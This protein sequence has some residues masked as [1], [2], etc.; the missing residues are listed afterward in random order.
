[1]PSPRCRLRTSVAVAVGAMLAIAMLPVAADAALKVTKAELKKGS[2]SV[3]GSGAGSSSTITWEGDPVAVASKSGA[4]KFTTTV[5]PA[6]LPTECLA[7][8]TLGDGVA[9]VE[10]LISLCSTGPTGVAGPPGPKG[11]K[12]DPGSPGPAGTKGDPGPDGP[13]GPT[14]DPGPAGPEGP[15]G[16]Q[17]PPGPA[18]TSG[19]G[20]RIESIAS[21]ATS[22][23]PTD[24]TEA[25][26]NAGQSVTLHGEGL[27]TSSDV[28]L[29]YVDV[30][31]KL[32]V[33]HLEPNAAAPDGKTATVTVP[34]YAN[35]AFPVQLAGSNS[36]VP[37][38]IVPTLDSVAVQN[39]PTLLGSG[40]VEGASSYSFSRATFFD[41]P[42]DRNDI[43]VG[44]DPGSA[45]PNGAAYVDRTALPL[46]GLG[47]V[48]V[49]VTTTG[50]TSVA[51]SLDDQRQETIGVGSTTND[52]AIVPG[53]TAFWVIDNANPG[54]ILK[55]DATIGTLQTITMSAGTYGTAFTFN[56]AGLQILGASMTLNATTVAAGSLLVLN[57]SPNT[58]RIVAI[59]PATGGLIAALAVDA[60]Y[61]LTSGV[62]DPATGYL[63]I[64]ATNA[65]SRIV[66]LSPSNGLQINTTTAPFGLQGSSGMAIDP[67]TG[68][69][70]LGAGAGGAQLV[71]YLTRPNG[72]VT[73]LRRLDLSG[74][75]LTSDISGLSFDG[76]GNLWVATVG[77][78][79]YRAP[80]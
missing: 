40:F 1:M 43:E 45:I 41:T 39:R 67:V 49:S 57:G 53:T 14:G 38:Q 35:G 56:F 54:H 63:F 13:P 2:V 64:A 78:T 34:A 50:G 36:R 55:I 27:S 77:G 8:G 68:H 31:G 70:W 28:V 17:G 6:T 18:G 48:L 69:L 60:N 5:I 52:F 23:T 71:E 65:T 11:D 16:P 3:A 26:A 80:L 44:A 76:Y 25:S 47:N 29:R 10:V 19:G 42:S 74:V 51:V 66:A 61:D 59:N 7:V 79:L 32:Q 46:R 72:T 33:T 75:G 37:L 62:F 12:G 20:P 22:G 58:D 9:T 21:V 15:E 73:E 4:F 30:D 24:P